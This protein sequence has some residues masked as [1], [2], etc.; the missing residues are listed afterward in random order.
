MS[1]P[2]LSAHIWSV[3]N[4]LR[5]DYKRSNKGKIFLPFTIFKRLDCVYDY[6]VYAYVMI[7]QVI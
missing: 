1:I 7:Q 5:G 4:L 6:A 3:A 2:N